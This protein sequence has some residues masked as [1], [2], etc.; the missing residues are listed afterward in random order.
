MNLR[1]R[2]TWEVLEEGGYYNYVLI[3]NKIKF[4]I[5]KSFRLWKIHKKCYVDLA[6]EQEFSRKEK[7]NSWY[8]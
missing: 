2:E 3:K 1:G 4:K 7:W 6:S 8:T 5:K